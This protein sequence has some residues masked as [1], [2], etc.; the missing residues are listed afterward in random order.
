MVLLVIL[1]KC[2][3]QCPLLPWNSPRQPSRPG[4]C[5]CP[6]PVPR[7]ALPSWGACG[8]PVRASVQPARWTLLG[9]DRSVLILP[10]A[11]PGLTLPSPALSLLAPSSLLLMM[12]P[13]GCRRGLPGLTCALIHRAMPSKQGIL[14]QCVCWGIQCP[15]SGEAATVKAARGGSKGDR[16]CSRKVPVPGIPLAAS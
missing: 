5:L 7:R 15:G 3:D 11:Q 4:P 10:A 13:L 9:P 8:L 6:W 12:I 2:R 14:S 16:R 1:L